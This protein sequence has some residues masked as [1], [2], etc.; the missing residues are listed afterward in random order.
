MPNPKPVTT[1]NLTA[2]EQQV[3]AALAALVSNSDR[4]ATALE[5]IASADV[6]K[7]KQG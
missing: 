7:F 6:L 1:T 4:I 2:Y 5:K 3:L